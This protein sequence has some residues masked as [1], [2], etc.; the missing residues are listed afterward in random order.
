MTLPCGVYRRFL[1]SFY[2]NANP[3][4]FKIGVS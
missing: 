4:G 2:N 1:S 3:L